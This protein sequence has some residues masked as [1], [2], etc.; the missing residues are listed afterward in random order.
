MAIPQSWMPP[1]MPDEQ[2]DEIAARHPN[3]PEA[4]ASEAWVTWANEMPVDQAINVTTGA[5]SV[6]Y[7]Q[8][9]YDASMERARWYLSRSKDSH[10][11]HVGGSY[12][13][14]YLDK[15][16]ADGDPAGP[17]GEPW[18]AYTFTTSDIILTNPQERLK[19]VG[20]NLTTQEHANNA[21]MAEIQELAHGSH[22]HDPDGSAVDLSDYVLAVDANAEYALIRSECACGCSLKSDSA[23]THDDITDLIAFSETKADA[24]AA[25]SSL[26]TKIAGAATSTHTHP[27]DADA[28]QTVAA[29]IAMDQRVT[30]LAADKADNGHLHIDYVKTLDA[31][32][33]RQDLQDQIDDKAD[34]SHYHPGM[35]SETNVLNAVLKATTESDSF[36]DFKKRLIA[37]LKR[38]S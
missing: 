27:E 23:H 21:I 24:N 12:A 30:R 20:S 36:D 17:N 1:D 11:V 28:E 22:V 26:E 7:D 33:S 8:T 15:P 10:S 34:Y 16:E 13:Y 19:A 38:I 32:E 35:V 6:T 5:Q 4:A 9:A 37:E 29:F 3:D 25:H 14:G 2:K 31:E 18:G